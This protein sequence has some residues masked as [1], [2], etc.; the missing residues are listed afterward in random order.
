MLNLF[1]KQAATMRRHSAT[2][3]RERIKYCDYALSMLCVQKE[4]RLYYT[5][6]QVGPKEWLVRRKGIV[7]DKIRHVY[8]L[9]QGNLACDCMLLACDCMLYAECEVACRHLIAVCRDN[10]RFRDRLAKL[11]CKQWLN[12]LYIDSF[13]NFRVIMPSA[14]QELGVE[15]TLFPEKSKCLPKYPPGEDQGSSASRHMDPG[16][17]KITT[18]LPMGEDPYVLSVARHPANVP[19][20]EGIHDLSQ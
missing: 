1:S 16:F 17:P 9:D 5:F 10:T 8:L 13:K 12:S 4:Q 14:E 3:D 19:S 18:I 15:Q 2:L 7:T 11:C 20:K 6:A